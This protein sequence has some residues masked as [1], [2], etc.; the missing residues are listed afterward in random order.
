M[1]PNFLLLSILKDSKYNLNLFNEEEI[2]WLVE[3]I[4]EKEVKGIRK[5]FINCI[6]RNKDIQLKP[7]EIVRQLY[8][9]RL[10]NSYKYPLK[11]IKFENPVH[12]GR[13]VKKADIVI[14]DKDRPTIEYIIIELKKPKLLDGKKQL[15]SYCNA[16]GAPIGV[17]TNGGQISFYNRKDPNYFEDISDIPTVDQTL[18]DIIKER[19][20]LKDL[21]TKDKIATEGKT[22]KQ[23]ILE[24]EDEVLANAGV[25]VFEEVFKLIFTKLYDEIKSRRDRDVIDFFIQN[26]L[27]DGEFLNYE[28]AKEIVNEID[29]SNF[30]VMEFRNTGQTDIELKNKIQKLFNEAKTKWAGVFADDR[31]V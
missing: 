25:D 29:D 20:T 11:R 22:L 7:E 14:F 16:T 26:A 19:F 23:I 2:N 9:Y 30:R 6:K 17:W 15:K 1:E 24:M 10:L 5:P 18:E 28:K 13:E 4:K 8:T 12:F 27:N 3:N 21:F 31:G